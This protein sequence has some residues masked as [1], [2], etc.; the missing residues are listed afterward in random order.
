VEQIV[1]AFEGAMASAHAPADP[2]EA[3]MWRA[4]AD[5]L[6]TLLGQ[7][8]EGRMPD[9]PAPLPTAVVYQLGLQRAQ[10]ARRLRIQAAIER[11]RAARAANAQPTT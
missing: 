11:R 4:H 9:H 5:Q 7:G 3:L 1:F 6:K 8:H 10:R 2:G